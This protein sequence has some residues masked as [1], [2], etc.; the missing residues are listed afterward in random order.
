M[1]CVD[2]HTI[3]RLTAAVLADDHSTARARTDQFGGQA[4]FLK[5][6]ES[7]FVIWLTKL[8]RALLVHSRYNPMHIMMIQHGFAAIHAVRTWYVVRIHPSCSHHALHKASH[9]V[10][11][12][13]AI[14]VT[15]LK[16]FIPD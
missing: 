5:I 9:A 11:T 12:E 13:H 15:L 8:T 7:R 4:I 10:Q 3:N 1:E 6:S 14:T 2:A 16:T